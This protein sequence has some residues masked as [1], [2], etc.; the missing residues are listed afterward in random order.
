MDR[1]IIEIV[2]SS[3]RMSEEE[4]SR[5]YKNKDKNIVRKVKEAKNILGI[6]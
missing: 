2:Q 4:I 1:R 3:V 5:R 6:K